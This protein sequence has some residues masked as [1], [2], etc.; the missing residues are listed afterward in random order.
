MVADLFGYQLL[1]IGELGSDMAYLSNCPVQRKT[2]VTH[3][4]DASNSAVVVA[5]AQHLPVASD[6][7]D[8]VILVHTL[9]FS[10]DPP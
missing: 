6:S 2:L 7:V 5:E 8:A 3:R 1:Q 4:A 9:D 10:R